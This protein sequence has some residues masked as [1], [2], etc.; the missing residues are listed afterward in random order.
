MMPPEPGPCPTR[1]EVRPPYW[2][3]AR[4]YDRVVGD[5]A[6][7]AV[8]T[9]FERALSEYRITFS[10]A[11]DIGCGTGTF[12]RY[13]R[14][15]RVPLVGVDR[16]PE[17][18]RRAAA[19][20]RGAGIVF[21]QQALTALRLPAPVDLITCNF[22]T[23]NY[24][25]SPADLRLAFAGCRANLRAGGHFLFDVIPRG[26][27]GAGPRRDIRE[28]R[29]P[30]IRSTWITAWDPGRGTSCVRMIHSLAT[31]F[32]DDR[33]VEE[34][35]RQRWYPASLLRRLLRAAG[36]EVRG[37]HDVELF[38]PATGN[39]DVPWAKFIAVSI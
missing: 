13:L 20:N 33:R 35:H 30:G 14:K 5:A 39:G 26:L 22:D 21:L 12:L 18:L 1:G 15:Y 8:R 28:I 31:G 7:P 27:A 23:L 6:F 24:L 3:L 36:F 38:G 16:S 9:S 2:G 34:L 32:S 25:L 29:L 10:S 37:I 11:A 4:F 19:K 17:M